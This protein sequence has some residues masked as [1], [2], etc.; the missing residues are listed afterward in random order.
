MQCPHGGMITLTPSQSRVTA[1]GSALLL[2]TDIAII[3]GCAFNVSGV[4]QPCV[5]VQWSAGATRVSVGGQQPL[6]STS[7][8]IC[9]SAAGAPQGMVLIGPAQ[10]RASAT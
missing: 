7:I 6:L 1:G 3:A 9:Q 10:T 4:P 8:G 2:T 5:S